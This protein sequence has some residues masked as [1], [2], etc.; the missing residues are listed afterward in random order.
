MHLLA[1]TSKVNINNDPE[2]KPK[3]EG[4]NF[5]KIV[6]K[7]IIQGGDI[8][9]N[10][11]TGHFSIYENEYIEDEIKKEVTFCEMGLMAL[12]NKGKNTNGSQFFIT[13]DEL[14]N[15]DGQYTIVGRVL[16]GFDKLKNVSMTCG[17][18][19]G[20]PLCNVKIAKSG[21]YSYEDY[22]K[23]KNNYLI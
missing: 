14:Q 8:S 19:D 15:L 20:E 10:D 21:I 5:F 9:N 22:M 11:G 1:K 7:F 16:K 12:A 3:Y 23:L 18:I 4:T 17:N 2:F 6:P 13:L